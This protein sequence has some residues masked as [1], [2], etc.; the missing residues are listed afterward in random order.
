MA[1]DGQIFHYCEKLRRLGYW[2]VRKID[3]SA[4]FSRG[5]ALSQAAFSVQGLSDAGT[6]VS[7][8]LCHRLVYCLI[9]SI[10][11]YVPDLV[12]PTKGPLN[13]MEVHWRQGQ[14]WVTNC[15]RSTPVPIVVAESCLPSL[16]FLLRHKRR[17]AA[18]GLISS[19]TSINPAPARLC[20]SFPTL[21]K[22]RAPDSQGALCKRLVPKVIP[23]N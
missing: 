19:L 2:F 1:L 18:L 20:W 23:L 21:L 4:H 5:L 9:F 15:F 16:T 13:M 10:L 8:H 7:P 11:S 12:T 14:R 6:G 3:S 22:A 17:M